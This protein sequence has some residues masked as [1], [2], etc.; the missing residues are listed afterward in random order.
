MWCSRSSSHA[1]DLMSSRTI[2]ASVCS[3]TSG[4]W[5]AWLTASERPK[6]RRSLA[7]A[8]AWLMQYWAAPRLAAPPLVRVRAGA[9]G[10]LPDPVLVH[11]R[12]RDVQP[13]VHLSE[14]G[15]GGNVDVVQHDLGMV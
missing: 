6:T 11:E 9:G 4:H 15:V 2:C 12:L 13:A 1:V 10:R 7:Y 8:T 5:M 14:D 3:S